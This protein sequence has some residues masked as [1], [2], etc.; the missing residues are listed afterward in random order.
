MKELGVEVLIV[1]NAAGGVNKE[2]KA[3][4][5]MLIRDH[6]NFSGSNPLVG[7]MMTDLVIDFQICRM[8]ILLDM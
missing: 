7:K 6:I 2:F 8:H 5:L 1:T 4:D 3:G